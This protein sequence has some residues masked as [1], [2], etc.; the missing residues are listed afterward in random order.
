MEKFIHLFYAACYCVTALVFHRH[1]AIILSK[2]VR[3]CM[4]PI[5]LFESSQAEDVGALQTYSYL[6]LAWTLLPLGKLPQ[7]PVL[8]G[9]APLWHFYHQWLTVGISQCWAQS[10]EDLI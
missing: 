4:F 10:Q 9:L 5:K 6:T 7:D 3:K 2:S 8:S 1:R